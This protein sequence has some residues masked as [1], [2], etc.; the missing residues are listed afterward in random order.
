MKKI[1]TLLC[2]MVIFAMLLSAGCSSSP[3]AK[4][5]EADLNIDYF[6]MEILANYTSFYEFID[7]DYRDEN[8]VKMIISTDVAVKDFKYIEVGFKESGTEVQF[9]EEKVLYTADELLPETPFVT[10]WLAQG[11][12]PHRGITY[13]DKSGT[14]KRFYITESGSDGTLLFVAF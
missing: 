11:T 9:F 6:S 8:S 1:R 5:G 7:V 4:T 14:A 13:V 12:M 3:A 10:T 2:A